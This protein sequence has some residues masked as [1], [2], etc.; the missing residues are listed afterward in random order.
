[1]NRDIKFRAIVPVNSDEPK[2]IEY[3]DLSSTDSLESLSEADFDIRELMQ[4]TGLKDKN[5]V[6][7][8]EG[9]IVFCEDGEFSKTCVIYWDEEQARFYGKS[10]EDDDTYTMEETYGEVIGNMYENHTLLA[11]NPLIEESAS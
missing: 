6:E 11:N 8:Y 9:D 2:K 4:Y 5:G 3:F 7:I 10:I 1:M